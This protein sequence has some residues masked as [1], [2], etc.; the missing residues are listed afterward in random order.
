MR[1]GLVRKR[2]PL[3]LCINIPEVHKATAQPMT[4]FA[5]RDLLCENKTDYTWTRKDLHTAQILL[6]QNDWNDTCKMVE[7]GGSSG[8]EQPKDRQDRA[9]CGHF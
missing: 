5:M 2:T 8:S 1:Q 6:S 7:P 4:I 9:K 3:E